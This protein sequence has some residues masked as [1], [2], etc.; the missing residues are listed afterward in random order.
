MDGCGQ[1][2]FSFRYGQRVTLAEQ[3]AI[4]EVQTEAVCI[5]GCGKGT[6]Q[7]LLVPSSWYQLVRK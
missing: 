1:C 4:L 5:I 7:A 3:R 2:V 6:E